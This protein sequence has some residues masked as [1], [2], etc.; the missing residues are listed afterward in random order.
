MRRAFIFSL[1]KVEASCQ[2]DMNQ[3]ANSCSSAATGAARTPVLL[4]GQSELAG[5]PLRSG[6]GSRSA[7]G[8]LLRL[9]TGLGS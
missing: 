6:P 3:S 1:W 8:G 9:P 4:I 5:R 7:S 2:G